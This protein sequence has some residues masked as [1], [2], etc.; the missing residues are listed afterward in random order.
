MVGLPELV[1]TRFDRQTP[2]PECFAINLV[3]APLFWIDRKPH[4]NARCVFCD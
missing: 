4:E 2:T 1:P 3:S